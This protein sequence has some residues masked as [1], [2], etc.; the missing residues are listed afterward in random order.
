MGSP[1]RIVAPDAHLAETGRRF[2]EDLERRWSRF[3]PASE[4]SRLNRLAGRVTLVSETTYA[5]VER[6]QQ[7]R[8][9]TGGAFNPLGLDQLERLGYDRPFEEVR[10]G[11]SPGR[12]SIATLTDEPIECLPE[13]LAVRLPEGSRFDPGGIGKGFAADL[14]AAHLVELGATSL[15]IELGGDVHVVGPPWSGATWQIGIDLTRDGV[16]GSYNLGIP[17][18]GVATSGVTRHMWSSGDEM[19]HHLIDPVTGISAATDLVSVTVAAA[20]TWWAEVLAKVA[21]MAGS[22]GVATILNRFAVAGVI[23]PAVGPVV[24]IG[25]GSETSRST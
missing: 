23:V 17:A 20:S 25:A 16:A 12:T 4:I 3:L 14:V 24:P 22:S 6:A 10:G 8:E 9:L 21:V 15:Q 19:V 18:G 5:L 7:A 2:V 11:G 13:I 1:C